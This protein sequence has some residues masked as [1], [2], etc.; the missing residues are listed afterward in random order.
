MYN[1]NL[2]TLCKLV[3]YYFAL[4]SKR[5]NIFRI[6]IC[7][8]II[9]MHIRYCISH[10]PTHS[11]WE[12]IVQH[13][14]ISTI[15]F[16]LVVFAKIFITSPQLGSNGHPSVPS[17]NMQQL[18]RILFVNTIYQQTID[19][20]IKHYTWCIVVK[21]HCLNSWNVRLSSKVSDIL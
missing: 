15:Y 20:C 4:A 12:Y 2:H 9:Y 8:D 5:K 19:I 17:G 7:V 3:S 11:V 21:K 14:G 13:L 6:T 16:N 1:A 10:P 18:Y